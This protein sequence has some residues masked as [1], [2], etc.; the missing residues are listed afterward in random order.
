LAAHHAPERKAGVM[1]TIALI[2]MILITALLLTTV[3]LWVGARWVKAGKATFFRSFCSV[4]LSRFIMLGLL[5]GSLMLPPILDPGNDDLKLVAL[6]ALIPAE[7]FVTCLIIRF[8]LKCSLSQ[9]IRAWVISWIAVPVFLALLLFVV[10]PF[11]AERFIVSSNSMAPIVVSWH[12]IGICPNCGGIMFSS[13]TASGELG[14]PDPDRGICTVCMQAGP[15][16]DA[17]PE[18]EEADRIVVNKLLTPRR[19]DIIAIHS[20]TDHDSIYIKRVVGLPGETVFIEDEAIFIND[21]RHT[22]PRSLSGLKFTRNGRGDQRPAGTRRDPFR[23]GQNEYFLLGDFSEIS[24]DSRH[25]GPVPRGNI[26][27]VV[28]LR[29]WPS[30][31]WHI[32]R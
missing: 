32:F 14:G 26:E 5:A 16:K 1:F 27:G 29:Y 8:C 15:I 28:T 10:R 13:A 20:P 19:W 2:V 23:L 17:S 25:W 30:S 18:V 24:L 12:H 4:F 9:A 21:E 3:A 22:P 31:R 11:V 6:L 7:P